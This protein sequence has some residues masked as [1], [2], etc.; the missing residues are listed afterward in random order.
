MI[1]RAWL[2]DRPKVRAARAIEDS[3]VSLHDGQAIARSLKLASF[4][5]SIALTIRFVS[6][7]PVERE[8]SSRFMYPVPS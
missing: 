1:R 2:N 3:L 4:T 6:L 5:V 8:K 7:F